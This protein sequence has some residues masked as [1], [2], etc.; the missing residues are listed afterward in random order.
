MPNDDSFFIMEAK[1]ADMGT[2]AC[3]ASNSAGTVHA[4]ANVVVYD[5]PSFVERMHDE[6]ALEG[7]HAILECLASGS[8]RPAVTWTK[9][10]TPLTEDA[11]FHVADNG[12]FL[13]IR[14][15]AAGDAGRYE[16]L[17]TN[18]VGTARGSSILTVHAAPARG[19][20]DSAA[21]T[22]TFIIIAV[23]C[24]VGTSA[25][26]VVVIYRTRQRSAAIKHVSSRPETTP[27]TKFLEEAAPSPLP[28]GPTTTLALEEVPG[29][30][31]SSSSSSKDSGTG[32]ELVVP[33]EF[34]NKHVLTTFG[35]QV[36]TAS[37][38]RLVASGGPPLCG[39]GG[40]V[41]E[42]NVVVLVK[43]GGEK[44]VIRE[45]MRVEI[46]LPP[47]PEPQPSSKH[48]HEPEAEMHREEEAG[49]VE[50]GGCTSTA[51]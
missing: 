29:G 36:R 25:A 41:E 2:Y 33:H 14:N 46:P 19:G 48:I 42:P 10:G 15:V 38:L 24:V 4:Y 17:L 13:V 3:S 27:L 32:E 8:P 47:Q 44:L 16:C 39:V 45:A 31:H 40:L 49:A 37:P 30:S 6:S 5:T 26:W 34:D 11:K 1:L 20:L 51:V 21:M 22:V 18:A 50:I 43:K 9:D 7:S 28:P 12:S 23:F 35:T